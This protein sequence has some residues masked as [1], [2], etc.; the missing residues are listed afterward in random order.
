V[1]I[2]EKLEKIRRRNRY[3]EDHDEH[4]EKEK[5]EMVDHINQ[6]AEQLEHARRHNKSLEEQ[7]RRQSEELRT[8][9]HQLRAAEVQH[10]Q[11]RQALELKAS[12]LRGAQIFLTK[13]DSLSGADVIAM[14][15][16]LNAEIL[17][18]SAYMADSTN[19]RGEMMSEEGRAARDRATQR[20][21]EPLVR[22]L[23]N[24][25]S[26][27]E[28]DP[29]PLP[30]QIALQIALV[31]SC[32]ETIESWIPGYPSYEDVFMAIYSRLQETG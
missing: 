9:S 2:A 12:E 11:T 27:R 20:I 8:T 23:A 24:K 22:T 7:C 5:Q 32:G 25:F 29:D 18:M 19:I 13:E 17:Q 26:R 1:Q 31:R 21:G 3:L 6:I 15:H 30:L 14:V 28:F 16:A 4:R 10:Q